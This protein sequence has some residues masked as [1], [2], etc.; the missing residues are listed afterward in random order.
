MNNQ[1]ESY[2][3]MKIVDAGFKVLDL[4]RN[5]PD[6]DRAM[7]IVMEAME[8]ISVGEDLQSIKASYG[9]EWYKYIAY[10]RKC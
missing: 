7:D 2:T 5:S 6:P 9:A 4:I 1:Q 10:D 3:D 8:R